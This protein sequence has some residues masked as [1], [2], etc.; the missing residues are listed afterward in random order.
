MPL[1]GASVNDITD[2]AVVDALTGNAAS[3]QTKGT[4]DGSNVGYAG[5]NALD[6]NSTYVVTLPDP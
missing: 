3:L 1:A 4:L 6:L 5:N 2:P